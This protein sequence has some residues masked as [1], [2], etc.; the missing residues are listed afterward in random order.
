MS[1]QVQTLLPDTK[2]EPTQ[3]NTTPA[4]N[5]DQPTQTS[6]EQLLAGKYKTVDDL[7]K[8]YKSLESEMGKLRAQV[9]KAPE[10]YE[11]DFEKMGLAD[12]IKSDDP[13]IQKLAPAFKTHGLSQEQ[14]NG[15]IADFMKEAEALMPK[16]SPEEEMKKLGEEGQEITLKLAQF[17]TENF[18][19]EAELKVFKSLCGTAEECRVLTKALGLAGQ[20]PIPGNTQGA[21]SGNPSQDVADAHKA[22]VDFRRENEN[23]I[24][25]D[26]AITQQ[27][28]SLHEQYILAKEK[29]DN[30]RKK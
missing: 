8:G 11:F 28:E 12:R 26:R 20:K 3:T 24:G 25:S 6:G 10:K 22:W 15:V 19:D 29:F 7:A 23:R 5:A 21:T 27:Y 13:L 30:S 1:D 18:K 2:S 9:P 16:Y 14:A 4:P 17:A